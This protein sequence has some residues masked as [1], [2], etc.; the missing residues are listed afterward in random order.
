MTAENLTNS[1]FA[2][3]FK[4]KSDEE[5]VEAFNRQVGNPGWAEARSRHLHG[6]HLELGRRGIDYS[7][8]G[9]KDTL[10]FAKQAH[11]SP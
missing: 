2:D 11:P 8:V 3:Y 10:S 6:I 5:L 1:H 4:D 9:D 7:A